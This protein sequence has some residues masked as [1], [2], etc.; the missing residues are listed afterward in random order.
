MKIL[1]TGRLSLLGRYAVYTGNM[2]IFQSAQRNIPED[3]NL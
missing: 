2:E 3:V 1:E